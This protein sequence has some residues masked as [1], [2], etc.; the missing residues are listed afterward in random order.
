MTFKEKVLALSA[1]EIV[2]LMIE[3]IKNPVI[4]LDFDTFGAVA[5]DMIDNRGER[6]VGCAA[7]NLVCKIN[8][9]KPF[10]S[11]A[12]SNYTKRA[13]FIDT[14]EDFLNSFE[15][16][17]DSLRCGDIEDYNTIGSDIGLP[18]LPDNDAAKELVKIDN[19]NY[20]DEAILQAYIDYANAL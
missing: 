1:K 3:A 13:N 7:T 9:N 16:A 8:D 2:L 10:E 20:Q 6:C 12:I 11:E 19:D 5:T 18:E 14:H 4:E 17:I 15:D